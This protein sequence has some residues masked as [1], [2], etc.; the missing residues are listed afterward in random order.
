VQDREL[1]A[2][3]PSD[4]AR[5]GSLLAKSFLLYVVATGVFGLIVRGVPVRTRGMRQPGPIEELEDSGALN[6]G[7]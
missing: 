6:G 1:V 7:A 2:Y 3:T 5:G 4:C